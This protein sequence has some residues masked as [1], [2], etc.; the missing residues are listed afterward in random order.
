M[1]AWEIKILGMAWLGDLRMKFSS[2]R[3]S[4]HP[5]NDVNLDL[6]RLEQIGLIE[7]ESRKSPPDPQYGW[8][9]DS[10]VYRPTPLLKERITRCKLVSI[11]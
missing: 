6:F 4:R 1:I 11:E 8:V 10:C 3:Y 7:A 2:C 9:F 5:Y